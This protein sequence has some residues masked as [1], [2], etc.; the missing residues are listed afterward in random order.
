MVQSAE[1]AEQRVSMRTNGCVTYIDVHT[2]NTASA[3]LQCSVL[4]SSVAPPT[5]PN[6]C[7]C[8]FLADIS[9]PPMAG[10]SSFTKH[11]TRLQQL[12]APL[13]RHC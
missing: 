8:A 7:Q 4:S 10:A 1:V 6:H 2:R 13:R 9:A 12:L 3:E 11:S 5:S